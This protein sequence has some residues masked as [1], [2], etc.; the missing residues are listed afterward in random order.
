[1]LALDFL[2]PITKRIEEILI[3]GHDR[4]IQLEFDHSLRFADS[5]GLFDRIL[6]AR[7]IAPLQHLMSFPI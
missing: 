2:K 3:G 6:R 1:M 7:I 4:P 5:R